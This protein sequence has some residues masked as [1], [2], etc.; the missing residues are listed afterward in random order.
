MRHWYF[1]FVALPFAT[2]MA[3]TVGSCLMRSGVCS[4]PVA[5]TQSAVTFGLVKLALLGLR[6]FLWR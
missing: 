6:R 1:W 4:L 5:C 3:F 2:V